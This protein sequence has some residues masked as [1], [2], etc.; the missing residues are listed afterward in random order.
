MPEGVRKHMKQDSDELNIE[1]DFEVRL[2]RAT[3]RLAALR[4]QEEQLDRERR[5]LESLKMQTEEVE[6]DRKEMIAK[7]TSAIVVL[8]SEEESAKRRQKE[9]AG[10]REE[11]EVL[12]RE[13]RLVEKRGQKVEDISGKIGIE[14]EIVEKAREVFERGRKK[15]DVLREEKIVDEEEESEYEKESFG[16]TEGVKIGIGFF[17]AGAVLSSVLY[18]LFLLVR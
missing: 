11:F 9:F 17:L 2:K 4:D 18:V 14:K 1:R 7:L 16:M 8:S 10:T 12:V 5:E 3:E 15:I 13:M 6:A